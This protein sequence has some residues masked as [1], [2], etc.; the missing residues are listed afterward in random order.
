MY[1]ASKLLELKDFLRKSTKIKLETKQK[2]DFFAMIL[3]DDLV[4]SLLTDLL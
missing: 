2:I 1:P 3:E 4:G